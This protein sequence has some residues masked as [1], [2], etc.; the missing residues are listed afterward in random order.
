VLRSPK[1]SFPTFGWTYLSRKAL[2]DA[3]AQLRGTEEGVRDEIGFMRIHR[4]FADRFFPGTSVL[5][6]RLRY[7]LFV[8]WMYR[9]LKERRR[10][11]RGRGASELETRLG[12]GLGSSFRPRIGSS[13]TA[14]EN[15]VTAKI[16]GSGFRAHFSRR[17]S[18]VLTR[19]V[20]SSS[21]GSTIVAM[22]QTTQS[23]HRNRIVTNAGIFLCFTSGSSSSSPTC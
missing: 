10:E 21:S 19:D 15:E 14:D 9:A 11:L 7:A 2:R 18:S 23:W 1:T 8:P 6:T 4:I 13:L 17:L 3:E 16:G 12:G 5:H 22:M 20:G